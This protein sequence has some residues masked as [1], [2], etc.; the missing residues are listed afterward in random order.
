MDH[1][2]VQPVVDWPTS[3][4]VRSLRGFLG[5]AG[6]YQKFIYDFGVIAARLAQLLKE[7]FS[8]CDEANKAFFL[9]KKAFTSAPVLRLPDFNDTSIMECDASGFGFGAVLHQGKGAIAFFSN[10][11]AP[12]HHALAAY[13][14][15]LIWSGPC[16]STL[17]ALFVGHKMSHSDS[18]SLFLIAFHIFCEL[19]PQIFQHTIFHFL[20]LL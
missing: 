20:L 6:Y 16:H 13:E 15:E 4:S 9:L 1:T 11:V 7:G 14:R 17:V 18:V 3:S 5:L 10:A 8:W 19:I 12:R 2:K